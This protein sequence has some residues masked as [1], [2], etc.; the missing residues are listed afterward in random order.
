[1]REEVMSTRKLV[2]ITSNSKNRSHLFSEPKSN[3]N[4]RQWAEADMWHAKDKPSEVAEARSV[5][6]SLTRTKGMMKQEL[7]RLNYV[8][9]KIDRD[10]YLLRDATEDHRSLGS[11]VKGARRTLGVLQ[12]QD[13]KETVVLWCAV[14]FFYVVVLF[15][16]WNRI[17]IP[18]F[19][20][21]W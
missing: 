3:G 7:E 8:S 20:P 18:F 14:S 9:S 13:L 5:S 10:G 2:A 19:S 1:M 17:G 12:R 6:A 4:Y 11:V 15:I 16:L 21:G